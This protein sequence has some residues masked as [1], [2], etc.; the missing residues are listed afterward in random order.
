MKNANT[1]EEIMR[2]YSSIDSIDRPEVTEQF[3]RKMSE[4]K[5]ELSTSP[6]RTAPAGEVSAAIRQLRIPEGKN[7]MTLSSDY[8]AAAVTEALSVR[9][10]L[11]A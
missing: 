11:C 5:S 10:E 9:K 7:Y 8:M 4:R 1:Y 2:K 6:I 3:A